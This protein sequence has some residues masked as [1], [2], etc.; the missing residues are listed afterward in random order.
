MWPHGW[1]GTVQEAVSRG[2]QSGLLFLPPQDGVEHTLLQKP[3]ENCLLTGGSSR[4]PEAERHRTWAAKFPLEEWPPK[5]PQTCAQPQRADVLHSQPLGL[6][7]QVR[8]GGWA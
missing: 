5:A 8:G 6:Y 4:C 1:L 7:G 2:Q 3:L